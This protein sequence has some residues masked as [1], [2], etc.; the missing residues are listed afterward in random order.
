MGL[1]RRN[2][3]PRAVVETEVGSE[4][5]LELWE[6]DGLPDTVIIS[7]DL[8]EVLVPI[9]SVADV[10]AALVELGKTAGVIE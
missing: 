9:E 1:A 3:D 5:V 7:E 4:I 6:R 10:A 8:D 2:D